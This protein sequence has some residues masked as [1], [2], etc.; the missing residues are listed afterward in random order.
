MPRYRFFKP[1][2]TITWFTNY[3]CTRYIPTLSNTNAAWLFTVFLPILHW[4]SYTLNKTP[5]IFYFIPCF[6]IYTFNKTF[7]LKRKK[8]KMAGKS[9]VKNWENLSFKMGGK[10]RPISIPN[11]GGKSHWRPTACFHT[12]RSRAL[13]YLIY[14]DRTWCENNKISPTIRHKGMQKGIQTLVFFIKARTHNK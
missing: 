13:N 5:P 4:A 8:P 1:Q 14:S 3:S 6:L 11:L 9:W 7:F 10:L 12:I 2:N